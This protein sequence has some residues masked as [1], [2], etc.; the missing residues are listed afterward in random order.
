[1]R[2]LIDDEEKWISSVIRHFGSEASQES[3]SC[4]RRFSSAQA[5]TMRLLCFT[6]HPWWIAYIA[7]WGIWTLNISLVRG[8]VA[9]ILKATVRKQTV[10]SMLWGSQV[11]NLQQ[12]SSSSECHLV[13]ASLMRSLSLSSSASCLST[14]YIS[15]SI[16]TGPTSSIPLEVSS[17]PVVSISIGVST[18][19]WK[20]E[21]SPT[22]S[23]S[24]DGAWWAMAWSFGFPSSREHLLSSF[25]MLARST[26]LTGQ[27]KC[28]R[29]ATQWR[30]WL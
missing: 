2:Q 29:G 24:V 10:P 1:M 18:A 30:K 4:K 27:A 3:T 25:A 16:I 7:A 22:L 15:R 11:Q 23:S 9:S 20:K 13:L 14:S 6:Y 26:P 12:P 19:F 8:A 17:S 21:L 28:A 5:N